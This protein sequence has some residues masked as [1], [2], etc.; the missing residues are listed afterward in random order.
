MTLSSYPSLLLFLFSGDIPSIN[1]E[2]KEPASSTPLPETMSN[3]PAITVADLI[4]TPNPF[5]DVIRTE[6][7][8]DLTDIMKDM[9]PYLVNDSSTSNT[10]ISIQH[11]FDL[12]NSNL[13]N[14]NETGNAIDKT[15][16]ANFNVGNGNKETTI[17]QSP[18]E[19]DMATVNIKNYTTKKNSSEFEKDYE[20]SFSFSSVLDMLFRGEIEPSK[21]SRITVSSPKPTQQSYNSI[22]NDNRPEQKQE[23]NN[24]I[25]HSDNDYH[26]N[27]NNAKEKPNEIPVFND[28]QADE[29]R[30][31]TKYDFEPP[32]TKQKIKI[33]SRIDIV[34]PLDANNSTIKDNLGSGLLKLAGCNIYGRMYRVGNII[35]EL[36]S[37]CLECMCTEFG[38]QCRKHCS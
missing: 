38:V 8:P 37:S 12:G 24:A 25:E 17:P 19:K 27:N 23:I 32:G 28:Y 21:P 9:L 1:I 36:S 29:S 13:T 2:N 5:K 35:S 3:I 22:D 31:D 16:T 4:V 18:N 34:K 11:N 30:N 26:S 15:S 7:A 20:N 10:N 14:H 33:E 6:P